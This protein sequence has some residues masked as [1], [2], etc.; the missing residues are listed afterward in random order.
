[1]AL[2]N[3]ATARAAII[4]KRGP[5]QPQAAPFPTFQSSGHSL[6]PMGF[7]SSFVDQFQA[8][9]FQRCFAG[10][11]RLMG[12][13]IDRFRC[14]SSC[15]HFSA[16]YRSNAVAESDPPFRCNACFLNHFGEVEWCRSWGLDSI[17]EH[18]LG[19]LR[20]FRDDRNWLQF[21]KP[22]DLAMSVSIEAGELLE[23]FQWRSEDQPLDEDL[24]TKVKDEAADILLYLLLLTDRM[25]I[26]LVKAAGEKIDRNEKRFPIATSIG[27]AKPEDQE[28]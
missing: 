8:Q 18:L 2:V 24:Q 28:R 27:I 9:G 4:N 23:A 5:R 10:E 6:L 12:I 21:H 14:I 19:R 1:M 11:G 7:Q 3:Q 13:E 17:L 16:S 25:D 22:K 26:D 20:K 15:S